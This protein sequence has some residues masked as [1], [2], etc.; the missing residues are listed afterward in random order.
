MF[1]NNDLSDK[2]MSEKM[3]DSDAKNYVI[4]ERKDAFSYRFQKCD[5]IQQNGSKQTTSF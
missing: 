1:E 3:N 4:F 5:N 2:L